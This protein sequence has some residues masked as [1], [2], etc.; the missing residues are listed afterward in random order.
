M[1]KF[2]AIIDAAEYDHYGVR[3][4]RDEAIVGKG[5]GKSRVWVD[6]EMTDDELDGISTIKVSSA[7]DLV[8]ALDIL[9]Q[10]YC[11]GGAQIVLVGG[12]FGSWGE[13]AG[14]YIIKDNICLATL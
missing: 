11:F 9:R 4:H 12:Y 1:E 13:D 8:K 14:E 7:S 6:G 10:V 2:A 3:A 5:L